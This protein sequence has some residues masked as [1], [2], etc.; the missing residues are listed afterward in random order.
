MRAHGGRQAQP[1]PRHER[2]TRRRV[3]HAEVCNVDHQ[4]LCP[5]DETP[6]PALRRRPPR[7]TTSR[8]SPSAPASP[9]SSCCAT[10]PRRSP[11]GARRSAGGGCCCATPRASHWRAW[12]RGRWGPRRRCCWRSRNRW[13]ATRP[14]KA[15]RRTPPFASGRAS[16]GEAPLRRRGKDGSAAGR[17]SVWGG[18]LSAGACA[19]QCDVAT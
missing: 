2:R 11:T 17:R 7:A 3:R 5:P 9:S 14:S 6:L 16:L 15:G 13:T 10:T 18:A 4:R 8:A 12:R 1:A 19:P